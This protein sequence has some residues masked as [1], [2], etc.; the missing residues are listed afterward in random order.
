MIN[1]LLVF[2]ANLDE[3]YK[4]F[5]DHSSEFTLIYEDLVEESVN[6]FK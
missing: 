3:D 1:V 2:L 6:D 4:L 5:E